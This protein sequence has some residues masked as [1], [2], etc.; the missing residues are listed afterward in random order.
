MRFIPVLV[1]LEVLVWVA[2]KQSPP[3]Q[4]GKSDSAA[5]SFQFSKAAAVSHPEAE[6][7]W[8]NNHFTDA[9]LINADTANL[10]RRYFLLGDGI[11]R[12]ATHAGNMTSSFLLRKNGGNAVDLFTSDNF[13]HCLSRTEY[14]SMAE[15]G[16]FFVYDNGKGIHYNVELQTSAEG[17]FVILLFPPDRIYGLNVHRCVGC[18]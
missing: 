10:S 12:I 18:R 17:T 5:A 13:P 16:G 7:N 14:Y 4:S 8:C 6:G 11:Y 9:V 2:C 3:A 1:L 15:G